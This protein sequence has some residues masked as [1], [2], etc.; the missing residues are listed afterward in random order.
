MRL[1]ERVKGVRK[2]EGVRNDGKEE[3]AE[4]ERRGVNGG[5]SRRRRVKERR[6]RSGG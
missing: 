6:K 1:E 2:V 3:M 4:R 5:R